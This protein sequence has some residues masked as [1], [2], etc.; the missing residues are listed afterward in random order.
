MG[1][2]RTFFSLPCLQS[3]WRKLGTNRTR[4]YTENGMKLDV[5]PPCVLFASFAVKSFFLTAKDAKK[6]KKRPLRN[7]YKN[8]I[9]KEPEM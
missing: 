5:A 1:R 4:P 2:K 6:R 7:S 3:P 8:N 9:I